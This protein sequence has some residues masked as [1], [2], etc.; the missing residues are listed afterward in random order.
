MLLRPSCCF[1]NTD[2]CQNINNG[3]HRHTAENPLFVHEVTLRGAY[4]IENN[5]SILRVPNCQEIFLLFLIDLIITWGEVC[6]GHKTKFNEIKVKNY[7]TLYHVVVK[8]LRYISWGL[9]LKTWRTTAVLVSVLQTLLVWWINYLL[10]SIG[11]FIQISLNTFGWHESTFPPCV[12]TCSCDNCCYLC[13]LD[14]D[15]PFPYY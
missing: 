5:L 14:Y 3:K 1:K 2:D 9:T 10:L 6:Q 4:L 7:K 13:N 15:K 12:F 11:L 8:N